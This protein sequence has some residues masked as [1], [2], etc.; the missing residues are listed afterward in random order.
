[1]ENN[2]SMFVV[3]VVLLAVIIIGLSIWGFKRS[4]NPN[5]N[6]PKNEGNSIASVITGNEPYYSSEAKVMEFYQPACGWCLKEAPILEEL[7]K[8][9]YKVKPMDASTDPNFWA[10]LPN[11]Q[12][13]TKSVYKLKGTPTFIAPD[14][15]RLE[16]FQ[17]KET[18]KA[19]LDK[20]K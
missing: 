19:F 2:K 3:G 14:G 9:G 17:S 7:S 18:L 15:A 4:K 20:Y 12:I 8:E 6:Q 13:N 11:G 5:S 1:M 16:G 10:Q